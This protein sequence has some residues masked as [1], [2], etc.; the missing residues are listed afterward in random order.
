MSDM[1]KLV[2]AAGISHEMK[3]TKVGKL[4]VNANKVLSAKSVPGLEVKTS[5]TS[6]GVS[7][8]IIVTKKIERPVHLCFGQFNK[9]T[10]E[11]ELEATV[12]A[13]ASVS[14]IGHCVFPGP[15]RVV[16]RMNGKIVVESGASFEY[17]ERHIHN[18]AGN[19]EVYPH[20]TVDVRKGGRY[21]TRFEL[22]KGRVGLLDIDY[23][24]K[25]AEDAVIEMEARASGYGSDRLTVRETAE[26]DSRARGV[27]RSRI[28]VRDEAKAEV[29]NTMIA[30][31]EEAR[32]HV[33]CTEILQGKGEVKAYPNIEVRHPKAHITHEATLGGVDSKQLE[34]LMARGLSEKEAEELIIRGLLT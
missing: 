8:K 21:S 13:G 14:V 24:T 33:E 6:T 31:G 34:S 30:K 28:A 20:A 16:H 12:K 7:V 15:E 17:L 23:A 11:I 18:E 4:V 5:E 29:F 22:L 3:D 19:V 9:G 32:G 2:D 25:A 27:L 1:Q 26:L 10:Q